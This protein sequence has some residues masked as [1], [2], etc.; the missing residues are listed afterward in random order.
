[1][2]VTLIYPGIAGLGFNSLGKGSMDHNWINLG[3]AYIGAYLKEHNYEVDLIDLR[4]SQSWEDVKSEIKSRHSDVVGVYFNTPN[5]N[6]A[7]QCCKF[8][9]E[10]KKIVVVGG[11]HACVDPNGLIETGF[12]DYVI[13]GEGEISFYEL[14]EGINN[15]KQKPNIIQGKAFENLDELPFPDRDLYKINKVI[16]PLRNFPFLDNGLI[17]LTSRGCPYNCSFCQPLGRNMFGQRVRYR[18][19]TNVVDEFKHIV[20]KYKVKYVSFQDDTFTNRKEWV[21][22]L[23]NSLKDEN[24]D[25][26]WS[27]Q[28]RVDTFDEELAEAMSSAGCVCLFFGFESGSQ[29]ILNFLKKGIRADDSM[30]IGKL[31]KK[32]GIIILADYMAGIPRETEEDLN[33]TLLQIKAIKPELLSVTYFTPIPGCELYDYCQRNNLIKI[34]KF[35]DYDRNPV[36]EKIFG[37]DYRTVKRYRQRMFHYVPKWFEEGYFARLAIKRWYYLVKLGLVKEF[38]CEFFEYTIPFHFGIRTAFRK[39]INLFKKN[40]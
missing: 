2:K 39:M 32:Y 28:S 11:P 31:C 15:G 24:L 40:R 33:Q 35:E 21:L 23:C 36:S 9:K 25:V 3:L 16:N 1:M 19:V 8:A 10:F 30:Q 37:V 12:I 4:A 26:Q 13:T 18:S 20:E 5:Y 34:N 17:M 27:A 6:N 29:R 14:L 38:F 22:E 7:L